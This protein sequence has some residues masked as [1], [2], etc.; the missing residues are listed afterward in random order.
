MAEFGYCTPPLRVRPQ[1]CARS[2]RADSAMTKSNDKKAAQLGMSIG[3]ATHK[4]RK[5]IMFDLVKKA[6]IDRCYRCGEQIL[7]IDN[8]SIEHKERWLDSE[9]PQKLFFDLN[10]IAFSHLGCN[11]SSKR[12]GHER[13]AM[14]HGTLVKYKNRKCRCSLCKKANA[15]YSRLWKS[16]N[17]K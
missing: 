2:I 16:K 10:N 3:M 4:L 14:K 13:I 15:E 7:D 17:R 8:F 9:N 1:G 11:S 5:A 12:N 6:G